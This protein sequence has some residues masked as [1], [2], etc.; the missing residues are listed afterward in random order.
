[1]KKNP[2]YT[3][4]NLP[5]GA[6]L[7]PFGQAVA[8]QRPALRLEGGGAALWKLLEACP[9]ADAAEEAFLAALPEAERARAA[10]DAAGFVGQMR[11]LGVLEGAFPD[12]LDLAS[13]CA[14]LAVGP[15]RV[16]LCCA[17]ALLHGDFAPY[18]EPVDAAQRPR[19]S[20]A[21]VSGAAP[22]PAGLRCLLANRELE[23]YAG[24]SCLLLRFPTMPDIAGAAMT[25][26]G[27]RA[28]ITLRPGYD[29]ARA[30]DDLFHALRH[31]ALFRAQKCGFF[32][33]H[34]ASVLYRERVW[35][36][37][38]SAGTG[39]STHAR[40]WQAGYGV[41]VLNGD[42]AL[43]SV[44]GGGAV[45]HPLP[46]CGTSGIA[47][48]ERHPLGGIAFLRRAREN[49]ARP[50]PPEERPLRCANRLV[51]PVWT[52]TLLQENLTFAALL[53]RHCGMWE[54]ECTPLPQAAE[55]LKR[56]IDAFL[57]EGGHG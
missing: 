3:L 47:R 54:L 8:E 19:Q 44:T 18:L 22:G 16:R 42:L 38:A 6:W 51:S 31:V 49:A 56:A 34:A 50:L 10:G 25:P 1:M 45:F 15:L 14:D 46:W 7:L 39:K 55:T 11:A 36:F 52:E 23:V 5:D 48:R 41:P 27:D 29:E 13:P 12:P 2:F 28:V 17:E 26:A 53:A 43:L 30:R 40:L 33:M 24:E 4:Q 9:D 57:E 20:V 32:A 37:S 35:L 21:V